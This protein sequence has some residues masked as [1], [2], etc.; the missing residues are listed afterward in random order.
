M[1]TLQNTSD[2]TEELSLEDISISGYDFKR[3]TAKLDLTLN[4]SENASGISLAINYSTVLFDKPTIERMLGHYEQLLAGIVADASQ[5]IG[6]L[7]MLSAQEKHQ[8]LDVFNATGVDYPLDRTVVDLF[9]EQVVKSPDAIAVVFEGEQLSYRELDERSNQ[10][11][12]YLLNSWNIKTGDLIGV[13][14]DR[15]DSLIISFLAILKTGSAYIPIDPNYPEER[16]AH[17][18]KD[19]NCTIII[20]VLFLNSFE[21]DIFKCNNDLPQVNVKA[22]SLAYV[23]YT[24]GS[25]GMP[26]GVMVEHK[27][28]VNLCF[29]HKTAYSVTEKSRSSL[30]S[31]IG[32]D[33]SVWE[34]YPYLLFGASLYPVSEKFRYDLDTF[35]KFL[36]ENAISHSYIP[37]LL[38]ETI[39]DQEIPLPH[40][41]VLTGGDVLRINKSTNINICNNY[42]PT[43]TTV[44]AAYFQLPNSPMTNIPIGKPI[45]NTQI[46]ILNEYHDLLPVGVIGELCIGGVGVARGYLNQ[47]SL[48]AEKFVNNP[49]R[50]GERLYKT[51]DLARWLPDGNLEYIGRS[52]AQVKIRGYR[53]ELG[54]IENALSLMDQV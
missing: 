28:L 7:S 12:H 21:E 13:V 16:K 4:V 26:K 41:T 20:D 34:I 1:F 42:G 35:S 54:E 37:T 46:Y 49:F 14:L 5:P 33:A 43:E 31:Q 44:V 2:G 39:I 15:S 19:S 24:S 6:S 50:D 18:K 11:A 48:T 52:D 22:D 30:F 53:I 8:L 9:E 38:C 45:H 36:N 27:N 32:F 51:G 23:I 40:T 17:I 29:W 47:E 25:T 3:N 10:L